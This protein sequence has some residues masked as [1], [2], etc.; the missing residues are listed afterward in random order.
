[1][2]STLRAGADSEACS[3]CA[4]GRAR[5]VG[6]ADEDRELEAAGRLGRADRL[7]DLGPLGGGEAVT[8]GHWC[9]LPALSTADSICSASTS[10]APATPL[11]GPPNHSASLRQDWPGS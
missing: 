7:V 8:S 3:R 1:M 2:I 11:R 9:H 10:S 4:N 5:A 6:G